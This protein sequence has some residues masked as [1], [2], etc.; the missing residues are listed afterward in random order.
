M[1][2]KQGAHGGLFRPE[3]LVQQV[4]PSQ[5]GRSDNGRGLEE[6]P[7]DSFPF[8][9]VKVILRVW[10]LA[11]ER[12]G[13]GEPRRIKKAD[14]WWGSFFWVPQRAETSF[15]LS[16][17][18]LFHLKVRSLSLLAMA[19]RRGTMRRRRGARYAARSGALAEGLQLKGGK[20]SCAHLSGTV[21]LS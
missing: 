6:F 10:F 15:L 16:L 4:E 1:G 9:T 7:L 5:R 13:V 20:V 21:L 11:L 19:L 17:L 12:F 3:A 14:Y 18:L 8:I 2:V